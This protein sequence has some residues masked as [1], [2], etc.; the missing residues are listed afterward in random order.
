MTLTKLYK[1]TDNQLIITLPIGFK[2]KQVLVTIDDKP[3]L[4]KDKISMMKLAA[5]DPLYLSD[6]QEVNDDFEGIEHFSPR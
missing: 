3:S 6:L 2:D 1:V 5:K 4:N